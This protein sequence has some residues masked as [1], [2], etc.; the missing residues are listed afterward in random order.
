V[1]AGSRRNLNN[2]I[3]FHHEPR[4]EKTRAF[5]KPVGVSAGADRVAVIDV[6][7]SGASR[8]NRN[9]DTRPFR[10]RGKVM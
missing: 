5:V 8:T 1:G 3:F 6:D 4:A 7:M 9:G 2:V 10:M